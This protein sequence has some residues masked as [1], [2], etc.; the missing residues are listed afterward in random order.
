RGRRAVLRM[1]DTLG[2]APTCPR[3]LSTAPPAS[4]R[5]IASHIKDSRAQV[6]DSEFRESPRAADEADN[7]AEFLDLG[8]VVLD[9]GERRP[10]RPSDARRPPHR[11]RR[12]AAPGRSVRW[13]P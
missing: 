5:H 7:R 11:A 3:D 9:L 13:E 8:A 1:P 6:T 2:H 10:A 4:I 12:K